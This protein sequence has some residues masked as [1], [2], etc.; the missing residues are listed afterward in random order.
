MCRLYVDWMLQKYAKVIAARCA[1]L[2][3]IFQANFAVSAPKDVSIALIPLNANGRPE[4]RTEPLELYVSSP[5]VHVTKFEIKNLRKSEPANNDEVPL[6][7]IQVEGDFRSAFAQPAN[8]GKWT[9]GTGT[10]LINDTEAAGHTF[11]VSGK[12]EGRNYQG[13][14]KIT[15]EKVRVSEGT[16]LFQIRITDP[17]FPFFEESK[18]SATF[19][20]PYPPEAGEKPDPN[21]VKVPTITEA[22]K[23]ISRGG[24]GEGTFYAVA[25]QGITEEQA[26][27]AQIQIGKGRGVS[28]KLIKNPAGEGYLAADAE[29]ML[30][31]A[32][33]A[34]NRKNETDPDSKAVE[35]WL[36][37]PQLAKLSYRSAF[38]HGYSVGLF[39]AGA[40]LVAGPTDQAIAAIGMSKETGLTLQARLTLSDGSAT[41]IRS[42]LFLAIP[43]EVKPLPAGEF[44]TAELLAY[45]AQLRREKDPK[46]DEFGLAM[47]TGD[48]EDLGWTRGSPREWHQVFYAAMAEALEE[49]MKALSRQPAPRAGY[50]MGRLVAEG[51]QLTSEPQLP[52]RVDK[53]LKSDFLKTLI[54]GD[55]ELGR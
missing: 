40:D 45:A 11:T 41:E 23:Q 46:A 39:A 52:T 3:L 10:L 54:Y 49:Q 18:W 22:P 30:R 6:C 19:E 35:Q 32:L 36:S 48:F 24:Q 14:F 9:I 55:K 4:S 38:L 31:V 8:A 27:S 12:K 50:H 2:P 43:Q 28:W 13:A 1:L 34:S 44:R 15:A 37:S 51:L 21:A 42:P 53:L 33:R 5:F 47:L 7:D 16:N 20:F 29:G 25:I 17:V 26:S